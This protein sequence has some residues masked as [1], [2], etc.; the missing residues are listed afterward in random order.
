MFAGT[1]P[2]STLVLE[3]L[4]KDFRDPIFLPRDPRSDLSC[5]SLV[6]RASGTEIEWESAPG[7]FRSNIPVIKERSWHLIS[8]RRQKLITN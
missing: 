3:T 5:S 4:K 7:Q 2:C 8:T 6:T 1:A